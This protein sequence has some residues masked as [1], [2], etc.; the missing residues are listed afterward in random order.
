MRHAI[1]YFL[2]LRIRFRRN[3]EARAIVD[4]CLWLISEAAKADDLRLA[5]LEL[6][7]ERLREDLAARFGEKPKVTHH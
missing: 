3:P 1:F 6:E 4:R 2:E 7:V 5:E